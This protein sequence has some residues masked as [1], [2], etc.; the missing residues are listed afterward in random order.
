M[1]GLNT[2]LMLALVSRVGSVEE[3]GAFGIAFTTAQLM[4]IV[5]LFGV[6]HYQMTDYD[7]TYSFR[8]YGLL[9]SFFLHSDGSRLRIQYLG[10][11][12][13]RAEGTA[14]DSLNAADGAQCGGGLVPE[15]VFPEQSSGFIRLC[16][17]LSYFLAASSVCRHLYCDKKPCFLHLS[18]NIQ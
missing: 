9:R 8:E 6:S 4:Y 16:T 14:D 3:V 12:L 11:G 1:Y 7:K 5:G 10:Y 17:V 15:S 18:A 13:F 2:F